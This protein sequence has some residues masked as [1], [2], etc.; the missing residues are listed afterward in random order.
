MV[1]NN[2]LIRT[3]ENPSNPTQSEFAFL[4][5]ELIIIM[6]DPKKKKLAIKIK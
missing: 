5:D 1:D 6:F 3:S 4:K 2:G